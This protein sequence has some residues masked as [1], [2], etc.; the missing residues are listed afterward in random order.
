MRLY[1][2]TLLMISVMV[3]L[4]ATSFLSRMRSSRRVLITCAML[5]LMIL[6]YRPMSAFARL[7]V[8]APDPLAM[9]DA[10]PFLASETDRGGIAE[11]PLADH[12]GRRAPMV[13]R[14]T[15]GSAGHLRRVVAVHGSVIPPVIDSLEH[16][17]EDLPDVAAQNVLTGHGVTR[18]VIHKSLFKGDSATKL[19][20][21]LRSSGLPVLFD[22]LEGVVFS[23]TGSRQVH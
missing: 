4:G 19:I 20:G 22:G 1:L 11:L 15:Y 10:Y 3:S 23:L 2:V 13:T 17:M 7:S 18:L 21:A 5:V 8:E 6:E 12:G 14:Y 16:A 9:S